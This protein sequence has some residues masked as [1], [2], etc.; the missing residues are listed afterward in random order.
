VASEPKKVECPQCGKQFPVYGYWP[1][2]CERCRLDQL[3]EKLLEQRD[4]C[5]P[6]IST[7]QQ[8]YRLSQPAVGGYATIE[9]LEFLK[10]LPLC[11]L[12]MSFVHGLD[13]AYV[14]IVRD[15]ETCDFQGNRVSIYIDENDKVRCI[16]QE[17]A[18]LGAS[19]SEVLGFLRE[20][21]EKEGS[22]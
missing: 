11:N 16:R 22:Q 7:K 20:L 18:V 14:R 2:V 5:D 12:I 8:P 4:W 10:G 19:G 15:E 13:P 1:G 21:R 17:M 6:Y 9:V 3:R